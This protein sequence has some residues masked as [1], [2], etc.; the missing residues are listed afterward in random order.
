MTDMTSYGKEEQWFWAMFEPIPTW[1]NFNL[2][3]IF[4]WTGVNNYQIWLPK[5]SKN[6]FE[7]CLNRL[8][9]NVIFANFSYELDMIMIRYDFL[10]ARWVINVRTDTELDMMSPFCQFYEFELILTRYDFL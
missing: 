5:G 2:G 3:Q 8:P 4:M 1:P 6:D 10:E 7:Q 9:T